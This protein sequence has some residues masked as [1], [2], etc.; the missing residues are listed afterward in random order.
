M[1]TGLRKSYDG[2]VAVDGI[3]FSIVRGECYGFLGPNGAGKTTTMRMIYRASP[4]SAGSLVVLGHEASG[5]EAD[6]AI[7]ARI[8][9]VPQEDNLDQEMTVR[10]NLA[11]FCGFYGLRG[12]AA[13]AR[14]DELLAFA[15]LED[16]AGQ[17]VETLSGGMK[18]RLLIAR[19]LL[20][21][22]DL[23]V[24]DEPT[25]GLDP[26]ARQVLWEKL[27]VLRQ[28]QAT[29][30]LTTHYMDEAERLCDRIAIMEAGKIVAI[31]TPLALIASF[32]APHVVEVRLANLGLPDSARG[33]LE[34]G[35]RSE[36]LADRLLI[37][38][39]DAEPVMREV[40][41]QLPDHVALSRR[42]S[43]E[44]VYLNLTGHALT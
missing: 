11:L 19:G 32:A 4:V 26:R 8:G 7:K 40:L 18:R 16:K 6:R 35:L 1:A 20:G 42:G 30:I 22:P 3:D 39:D 23:I 17:R 29:L 24:L 9:V 13:R 34:L 37:Y 25:T 43:L 14:V 33:L 36:L 38:A 12:R 28:R 27:G 10:E 2:F 5:G 41:H 15:D 21:E 44:D 31:D